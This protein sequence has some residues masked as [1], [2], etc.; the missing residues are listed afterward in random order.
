MGRPELSDPSGAGRGRRPIRPTNSPFHGSGHDFTKYVSCIILPSHMISVYVL[1]FLHSL[2]R[3]T[4]RC[5]QNI[6]LG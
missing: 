1:I 3:P 6:P 5:K 2:K 4:T